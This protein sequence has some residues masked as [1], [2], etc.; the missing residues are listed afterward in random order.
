MNVLAKFEIRSS[1]SF[2]VLRFFGRYPAMDSV[3]GIVD[4]SWAWNF[5]ALNSNT[6]Q[7]KDKGREP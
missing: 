2:S 5:Q 6:F 1:L 3:P 4:N 7:F